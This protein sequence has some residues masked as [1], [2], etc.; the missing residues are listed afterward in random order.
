MKLSSFTM[1]RARVCRT[2]GLYGQLAQPWL[3]ISF[4]TL[5]RVVRRQITLLCQWIDSVDLQ[6]DYT[7]SSDL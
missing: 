7:N 4:L 5:N 3:S 2:Q 6:V 1:L